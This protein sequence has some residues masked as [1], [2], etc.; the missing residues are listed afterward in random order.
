[1]LVSLVLRAP[2]AQAQSSASYEQL[3]AFSAVLNFV[4]LNYVDSVGYTE[5]VRSGID[6]VLHGLDPHSYYVSRADWER[7]SA[8]QRGE[9][10]TTGLELEDVDSAVVVLAIRARSPAARSGVQPGDRVVSIDDTTTAGQAADAMALRLAGSGNSKVRVRFERGSRLE[11]DTFSVVLKR[12]FSP[13]VWIS[14]SGMVDTATGY[15]RLA[16]FGA[17]SAKQLKQAV[18]K[19]KGLGARRLILDLRNNPGGIVTEAV[20]IADLFLPDNSVVF[21]TEGRKP[22]ANADYRTKGDGSFADLPLQVLINERSASAAEAL[23]ASLQDNDR[24]LLLGR[25]SFGKALMQTIF[26]IEATGDNVWL[27]I[28]RVISPSGRI[29]QRRYKGLRYEQYRGLEGK[30]GQAADTLELFHT[31]NGRAVRGGG[32]IAPDVALPAPAALPVWWTLASDSGF[33]DAVADSVAALLGADATARDRWMDAPEEWRTRLLPPF[34]ARLLDRMHVTVSP[35][36]SVARRLS[37][38][39]ALRAAEVR[40]G[41]EAGAEF[42]MRNDPD[43]R[44]TTAYWTRLDA[45][46][47]TPKP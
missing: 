13:R 10:A 31:A 45:L 14:N 33:A 24:A 3:Q 8:L 47:G 30:G 35:D 32:G 16:E 25:R 2:T 27:T 23:A 5:L 26:F 44:A 1:L 6:G 22:G 7:R 21:R 12:E 18:K 29:I 46:L 19:L 9:L 38:I 17:E 34:Q 36:S 37:R 43:I 40:W 41:V 42:S 11:P 39:L 28:G 20:A 15:V 4:R